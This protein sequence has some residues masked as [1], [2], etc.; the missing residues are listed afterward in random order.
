MEW[1]V[2]CPCGHFTNY[3]LIMRI[4]QR[5]MALFSVNNSSDYEQISPVLMIGRKQHSPSHKQLHTHTMCSSLGVQPVWDSIAMRFAPLIH[6]INTPVTQNDHRMKYN[7][8]WQ[9][10]P[11]GGIKKMWFVYVCLPPVYVLKWIKFTHGNTCI[12][13]CCI[14]SVIRICQMVHKICVSSFRTLKWT[15]L[16]PN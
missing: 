1:P 10:H 9:M 8:N 7:R 4:S 3:E 14:S 12:Y 11:W 2:A 16:D 15:K 13:K 6:S 5:E